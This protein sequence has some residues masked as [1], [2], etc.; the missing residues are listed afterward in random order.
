MPASLVTAVSAPI[1]AGLVAVTVTPGSTPPC[2]SLIFTAD[3]AGRARAAALRERW[4]RQRHDGHESPD[5]VSPTC[6]VETSRR[7]I[8]QMRCPIRRGMNGRAACHYARA[9]ACS[10][11]DDV[12]RHCSDESVRRNA[13]LQSRGRGIQKQAVRLSGS[14]V[15]SE[16][17]GGAW[18]TVAM[19]A[20][21]RHDQAP[22]REHDV[23]DAFRL[24]RIEDHRRRG[25]RR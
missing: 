3:A 19:I 9:I 24:E 17:S 20:A 11:R 21:E 16:G 18:I 25:S 8:E 1:C 14:Q 2:A 4:R 22:D 10:S 6:H 12:S 13:V 23:I 15:V 5:D 7:G